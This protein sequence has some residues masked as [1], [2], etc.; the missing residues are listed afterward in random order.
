MFAD[1]STNF[2][3]GDGSI[4]GSFYEKD[5]GNFFEFSAAKGGDFNEDVVTERGETFKT[6]HRIWVTTVKENIDCGYRMGRVFKTVV[7]LWVEDEESESG[8]KLVKWNI[9]NRTEYR[10]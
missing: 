5:Y 6:N 1:S 8:A 7:Y 3:I 4:I 10:S 9:K 2:D